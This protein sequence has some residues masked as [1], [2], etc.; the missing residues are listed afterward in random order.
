VSSDSD[1]IMTT[2]SASTSS[3]EKFQQICLSMFNTVSYHDLGSQYRHD[4]W[5]AF[6]QIGD[7]DFTDVLKQPTM[8]QGQ[9]DQDSRRYVVSQL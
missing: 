9:L 7:C 4:F 5:T 6:P 8:D 2:G 3:N 1:T